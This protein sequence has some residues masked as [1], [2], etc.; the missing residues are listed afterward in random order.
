MKKYRTMYL[1]VIATVIFMGGCFD[2]DNK[3]SNSSTP[4]N[5]VEESK[6]GLSN[7]ELLGDGAADWEKTQY[8]SASAGTSQKFNRAYQDAPPMIPH[9]V[10]GMMEITKASNI[11]ITCHMPNVAPTVKATPIPQSHFT[12]F[13]P[14]HQMQNGEFKKSVDEA[15]N[16]V[17][18][19]K[20]ATLV[21]ARHNCTACHAP[22]SVTKNIPKND[23][24]PEYTSKDG[25]SKSSWSGD[26]FTDGLKTVETS[27]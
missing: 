5:G 12:N 17:S 6:M 24:Q 19:N 7:S 1:G 22:Q 27:K 14:K 10:D 4:K 21:P 25:A 2:G 20:Q 3:E 9:N 11:C 13:R 8:N 16:E 26:K 18:I 15:N 23:F